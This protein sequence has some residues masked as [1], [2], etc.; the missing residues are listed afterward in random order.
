[1]KQYLLAILSGPHAGTTKRLPEG[2]YRLGRHV[3][4]DLVLADPGIPLHLVSVDLRHDHL[5]ISDTA[6]TL[7]VSVGA[8]SHEV[9][10][11]GRFD[12]RLPA[13]VKFLDT[14]IM[15][16][17][18]QVEEPSEN[19][20]PSRKLIDRT[21]E[22]ASRFGAA[23]LGMVRSLPR[24]SPTLLV[25]LPAIVAIL[26]AGPS[27]CVPRYGTSD[28]HAQRVEID[29]IAR[30]LGV[31][32]AID[33][34]EHDGVFD[35]RG[36]VEDQE[37]ARELERRLSSAGITGRVQMT[38]RRRVDRAMDSVTSGY[39]GRLR[40]VS[41]GVG[42]VRLEG[43]A[44]DRA[45]L[46]RVVEALRRDVPGVE[47]IEIRAMPADQ[48]AERSRLEL[49]RLGLH[50]Q[51]VVAPLAD[52]IRITGRVGGQDRPAW[53]QFLKWFDTEAGQLARLEPVLGPENDDPPAFGRIEAVYSGRDPYV[54]A[55]GGRKFSV[56]AM[57][58]GWRIER[59]EAEAIV[60][61][62]GQRELVIKL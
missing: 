9:A 34:A 38:D 53:D 55:D 14:Q 47:K 37:V 20:T 17:G 4:N 41:T 42:T 33:V 6:T 15:I 49:R 2:R 36:M 46:D 31:G 11:A 44:A 28:A 23:T 10:A 26:V 48:L 12:G 62:R 56:G 57:V 1:M 40:T 16:A 61:R 5:R 22:R 58:G 39:R 7:T 52:G 13:I 50:H 43:V 32:G 51:L 59:I 24:P 27:M 29:R 60:L 21:K 45:E 30:S 8:E 19:P 3:D 54:I 25:G 18:E 35:I